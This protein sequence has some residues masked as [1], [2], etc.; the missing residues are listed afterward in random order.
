ML[1]I[2]R[3]NRRKE[4]F[5]GLV[6][7][8]LAAAPQECFMQAAIHMAHLGEGPQPWSTIAAHREWE[9]SFRL[10]AGQFRHARVFSRTRRTCGPFLP[11]CLMS[12][13]SLR[14]RP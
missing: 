2:P 9:K 7:R 10:A 3:I 5:G 13:A 8:S 4:S 14:A 1:R 11:T 12:L 6:L